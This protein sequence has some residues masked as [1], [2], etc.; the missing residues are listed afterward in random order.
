MCKNDGLAAACR[1][2]GAVS[3]TTIAFAGLVAAED[4]S[5][6][7]FSDQP[8]PL[9]LEGFPERPAP[10]FEL[11]DKFLGTGNLQRGFTLPGGAVWSPNLWVYGT[12][13]SA[14]QTFEPGNRTPA[15]TR[16]TEWANRLDLFANVQLAATERILVGFR[17]VDRNTIPARFTGYQ[18]EPV[19]GPATNRRGTIE[20]F[21]ATPR[22]LFFE[23]EFGELFPKLDKADKFSL[24]Y[25]IAVGRQP[26]SLQ[27]GLLVNDD[28][29]DMVSITRNSLNIPGGSTLRISGYYAWDQ[30]ERA[31][32]ARDEN[33][34][35]FGINA[36]ADFPVTTVDAD[37]LFVASRTGGTAAAPN[38]GDGFYAGIGANQR[39]GKLNTV[40]RVNT[41]IA[42]RGET[43]GVRNGT[44][45]F[46]ELSYTP[47]YGQD[48]VYVN[49]FWGIDDFTSAVRAPTAGGP[50]G[51]V[52]ILNAAVGLGRYGAPLSNFAD[53]S[54]GGAIGYQMF[55]GELRR[56]QLILE[57]GGRAPTK[58]PT[59][60]R[61]QPAAGIGTRYQQAFGRR[62]VLVLDLFGVARETASESYGG[63]ME[64]LVKF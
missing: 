24:D 12:M 31:D 21:S 45:L 42:L 35:L 51:R 1:L 40:F 53:N 10:L 55:F 29:I 49:G 7:R 33:A 26:L 59:L 3:L 32:N 9:R 50:L 4:D 47:S 36:A 43:A 44:L 64:F 37:A 41:S 57:L 15:S 34:V 52:G 63:R 16:V 39:L 58:A 30:I 48:L 60:L 2:W 14:V 56:R 8:A 19:G 25:G 20:A 13:R 28:S 46:A 23:G 27:D 61:Q 17:P 54:A 11:G 6:V 38:G 62:V 22:T 18:F 5:K